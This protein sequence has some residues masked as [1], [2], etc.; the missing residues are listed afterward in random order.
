MLPQL[1]DI[2]LR[3]ICIC[4]CICVP[5][6]PYISTKISA[7]LGYGVNAENVELSPSTLSCI[8]MKEKYFCSATHIKSINGTGSESKSFHMSR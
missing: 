8:E 6:F 1:F 4:I 5:V 2:A 7:I 3:L